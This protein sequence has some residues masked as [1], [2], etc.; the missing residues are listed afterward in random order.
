MKRFEEFLAESA[1]SDYGFISQMVKLFTGHQPDHMIHLLAN[2]ASAKGRYLNIQTTRPQE[3]K[4][5][6]RVG[7]DFGTMELTGF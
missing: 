3:M 2:M 6:K 7:L 1:K 4:L 5:S